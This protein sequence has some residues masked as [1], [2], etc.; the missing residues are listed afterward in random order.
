MLNS[1]FILDEN[2]PKSIRTLLISRGFKAEYTSKGISNGR[3][4]SLANEEKTTI[5]SRDSDFLNTSLFP[6][7]EYSGIIV[8][9]IH[10]PK[11]EKLVA[12]LSL[13][14]SEVNEFRG[15]LFSVTE[16]GFEVSE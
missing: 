13:L 5:I 14:L 6:P 9:V 7:K 1:K 12:A 2:I 11:A 4:A 3:L 15:K 8:F 10:P 16:G